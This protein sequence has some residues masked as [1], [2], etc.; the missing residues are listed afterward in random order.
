MEFRIARHTNNLNPIIDFY[1]HVLG[2]T[3]L[4][5]FDNHDNYDGVFLGKEGLDWHL[6]FTSSDEQAQHQFDEDDI[7][8]LYPKSQQEYDAI[9]TNIK[10]N[11]ITILKGKNP[12][13]NKY[14][15]M[16]KDPDGYNVVISNLKIS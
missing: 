11:N 5:N 7:L 13:W 16:V 12:Y 14:G 8:V 3:I 4:G 2:L 1:T 10:Q 6:E 15:L 9:K